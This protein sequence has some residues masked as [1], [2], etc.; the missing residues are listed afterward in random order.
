MMHL[1]HLPEQGENKVEQAE[2]SPAE[3]RLRIYL[4]ILATI[5]FSIFLMGVF[6]ISTASLTRSVGLTLSY[7][8]GM[9]MILLPCTLPM[10]FVIVPL[11]MGRTYKKG[12]AMAAVYGVGVSTTLALYGVG[13]A[14]VG[15]YLGDDIASQ[16]MW[17]IAGVAAYIFGLSSLGVINVKVPAY[18]G[19]LP[20][21]MKYG[22]YLKSFTFGLLV[23]NAGIG[24][25]CPH[26]YVIL[27]GIAALGDP[28]YGAYMGFVHGLGRMTPVVAIAILG[29]I[30][31]NATGALIRHK[32]RVDRLMGWAL[33]L[34][35]AFFIVFMAL[36][37]SWYQSSIIHVT[38]NNFLMAVGGKG[39]AE[40]F[41]PYPRQPH[42]E[43]LEPFT[44]YAPY[45]F[46]ALI[47]VPLLKTW[48]RRRA[49]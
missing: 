9:T 2:L 22:D 10:V 13:I 6:Y 43:L 34:F 44:P 11:T 32:D 48:L 30:G 40:T 16:S 27:L 12:L 31:V 38:W 3:K 24:C 39:L 33:I 4:I 21:F 37:H 17:F 25:P 23:G 18:S 19:P 35:G 1:Y 29:M 36:A 5:L 8:S 20:N 7:A 15:R 46:L 28:V 49:Q 14:Y 26:W 45:V 42:H 47:L 41:P